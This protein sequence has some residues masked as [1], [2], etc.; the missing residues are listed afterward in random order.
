M[1]VMVKDMGALPAVVWIDVLLLLLLLV[2]LV[3]VHNK[4]C[5]PG[6]SAG[7]GINHMRNADI[8][9]LTSLFAHA[10]TA[11]ASARETAAV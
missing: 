2:L 5:L 4:P 8:M 11:P 1:A 9:W 6:Y 10:S 3:H 7:V